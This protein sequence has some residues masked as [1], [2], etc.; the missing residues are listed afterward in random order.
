LTCLIPIVCPAKGSS[1]GEIDSSKQECSA[2]N[3]TFNIW[4]K[5]EMERECHHTEDKDLIHKFVRRILNVSCIQEFCCEMTEKVAGTCTQ[6]S[7]AVNI[8]MTVQCY[9]P[10]TSQED[11]AASCKKLID[12]VK[13]KFDKPRKFKLGISSETEKPATVRLT[14]FHSRV[15]NSQL[16]CREG[17][18]ASADGSRCYEC[19]A[20]RSPCRSSPNGIE[21]SSHGT[22]S[23]ARCECSAGWF[24]RLCECKTD[25]CPKDSLG[26]VCSG[27]GVCI[28]GVF[29]PP[30][31]CRNLWYGERCEC[32]DY[33]CPRGNNG[34]ICSGLGKC[35]CGRCQCPT[36][37]F[38]ID[39]AC[40]P[41]WRAD[42]N[43]TFPAAITM[44]GGTASHKSDCFFSCSENDMD[45][46]LV[47]FSNTSFGH[48]CENGNVTISSGECGNTTNSS[49][50]CD[51]DSLPSYY[52]SSSSCLCIHHYREEG[53]YE[54]H[55]HF[56]PYDGRL[57]PLT[58]FLFVT[59]LL[60][61]YTQ[62]EEGWMRLHLLLRYPFAASYSR[63]VK[64]LYKVLPSTYQRL[65]STID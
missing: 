20:D 27:N 29:C 12:K 64:P 15:T 2:N 49:S 18:R 61:V 56:T 40:N 34:K 36:D 4:G 55:L 39:T 43:G 14:R 38:T 53:A 7:L 21:C 16:F 52:M 35:K 62:D 32:S 41:C 19:P 44:T 54:L 48:S 6:D 13:R 50:F 59:G 10:G 47:K 33:Y 25:V 45:R 8:P 22:C 51:T 30:C 1:R 24:G 5:Y 26:R 57:T 58:E 3:I 11:D 17:C 9:C 46:V 65:L 28:P 63:S 42:I 60:E 31:H 37:T 23:C